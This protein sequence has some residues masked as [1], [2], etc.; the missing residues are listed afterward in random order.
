MK[1]GAEVEVVLPERCTIIA[2][3]TG[4]AS[5]GAGTMAWV[6][7]AEGDPSSKIVVPLAWLTETKPPLPPEP[8]EA[9][10]I[11][12]V[13]RPGGAY[14]YWL[15]DAHENGSWIDSNGYRVA[16]PEICERDKERAP[17]QVWPRV[18]RKPLPIE[19]RADPGRTTTRMVWPST[20]GHATHHMAPLDN[21]A[22]QDLE[23]LI[24][25]D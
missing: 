22:A 6:Q 7:L 21:Q 3:Y 4:N 16:W 24:N 17:V 8:T 14:P 10:A 12:I 23:R 13:R 5:V 2:T 20:T 9:N 19:F 11:V 25:R 1:I 18:E 15:G